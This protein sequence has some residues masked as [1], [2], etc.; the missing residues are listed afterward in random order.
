MQERK[1]ERV[2]LNYSWKDYLSLN[3]KYRESDT[4]F[5]LPKGRNLKAHKPT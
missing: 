3:S 2:T 5:L 4:V 1:N